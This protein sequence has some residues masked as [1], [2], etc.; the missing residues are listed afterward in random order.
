MLSVIV[1]R[2]IQLTSLRVARGEVEIEVK[3][4]PIKASK[5]ASRKR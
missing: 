4:N 5:R 3:L 2:E 1:A